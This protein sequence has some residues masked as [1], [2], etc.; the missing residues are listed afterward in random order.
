MFY[1]VDNP[2]LKPL[3]VRIRGTF[4]GYLSYDFEV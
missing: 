2:R 1:I 3:I 4:P